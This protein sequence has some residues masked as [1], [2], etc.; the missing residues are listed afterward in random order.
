MAIA[1]VNPTT[2]ETLKEFAAIDRREIDK[3]L[4]TADS[5]FRSYRRTSFA[6]RAGWLNAAAD[7]LEHENPRL[8]PIMTLEMGKLLS[9]AEAEITKCAGGCRFYAENAERFL[10]E[11]KIETESAH[12]FVRY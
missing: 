11:Q 3:K 12:N 10:T 1:S 6:Q 9:A 5:A 8:A 2:G 7:L 4:A